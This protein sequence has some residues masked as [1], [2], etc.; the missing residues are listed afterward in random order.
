MAIRLGNF[1]SYG[2]RS[3]NP[4]GVIIRKANWDITHVYSSLPL[5]VNGDISVFKNKKG[6]RSPSR[7]RFEYF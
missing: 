1:F 3:G 5:K 6:K 4:E 7:S 2:K